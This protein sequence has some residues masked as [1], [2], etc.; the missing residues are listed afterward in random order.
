MDRVEYFVVYPDGTSAFWGDSE[1]HSEFRV[2]PA[3][4]FVAEETP[5]TAYVPQYTTIMS[6]FHKRLVSETLLFP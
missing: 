5:A 6:F 4:A 2:G 3:R 1:H